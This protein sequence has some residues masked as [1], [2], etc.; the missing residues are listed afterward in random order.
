M[1]GEPAAFMSYVRFIDEHDYGRLTEFRKRLSSEVRAQTGRP[2]TIFQDR[3]DIGFGQNWQQRIDETIDAAT[4]LIAI[5][6]PEFFLSEECRREVLRFVERER[7]LRRR[8][9]ILPV[10][11]IGA[12]E[13]DDPALRDGDDV[14]RVLASRQ[15]ADWRKLR[16]KEI[17]SPD[18]FAKIVEIAER[19]RDVVWFPAAPEP[20]GSRTGEAFGGGQ[21][22]SAATR[23]NIG[24]TVTREPPT[25][26]VDAYLRGDYATVGEAIKAAR[27]GDRILVRP[28]LYEE[29]LVVDRP[30]EILGDGPVQDIEIRARGADAVLFGAS[31]GLIANLTLRQDGGDGV[32]Y[33]V[34]VAQGRLEL[35]GCD[36]T[37]QS[38][39][40][41]GIHGG[42][43]PRLRNNRIHDGKAS[44]V[45]VYDNGRGRLEDNDIFGHALAGV[46]IRSGGNPVLRGNRIHDGKQGG[47][48]VYENGL[49]ELFDNEITG[50]ELSGVQIRSGGNPVLRGNRIHDN[51]QGGVLVNDDGEGTLENNEISGNMLSGVE[52]KS[53]G[54][55]VLRGNKINR[56][57]LKAVLIH[58]G[59]GG[60]VED[61][62][63][64]GNERGAWELTADSLDN[65]TR[66]R[67]KE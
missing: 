41:V 38:S 49:G 51:K 40:C 15:H 37:S 3:A 62:D 61:N 43:D 13:M 12:R 35:E 27:A 39:S 60:T 32:W 30:L 19:I 33:A 47:V 28:G 26:I 25:H 22:N 23:K 2:F 31:I 36:I 44:G 65:V 34:D 17:S 52:V 11:Y 55:P 29:G 7:Q 45:N 16:S 48:L 8:D 18:A 58:N 10:Y 46:Q 64:T 54:H 21:D 56:N 9:L 14:A 59:G 4:L 53:G 42:A 20:G 5:V 57:R 1:P 66:A 67:N 6:T 50:N 24:R 63:L